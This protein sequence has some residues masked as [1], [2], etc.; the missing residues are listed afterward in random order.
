MVGDQNLGADHYDIEISLLDFLFVSCA[1][2]GHFELAEDVIAK[3]SEKIE[4]I[5]T[6][7]RTEFSSS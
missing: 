2:N 4:E 3:E 5:M 1:V 7:M 6:F